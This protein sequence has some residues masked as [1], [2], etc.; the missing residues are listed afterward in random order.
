MQSTSSLLQ[1]RSGVQMSLE[2][3][4]LVKGESQLDLRGFK[5][6]TVLGPHNFSLILRKS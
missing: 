5:M 3:S 4:L 6:L 1:Q 2:I